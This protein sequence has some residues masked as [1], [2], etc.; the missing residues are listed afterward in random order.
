[1][2]FTKIFC[3]KNLE[4]YGITWKNAALLP[5]HSHTASYSQPTAGLSPAPAFLTNH[6]VKKLEQLRTSS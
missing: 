1:M 5:L 6:K 3:H 2:K 4:L